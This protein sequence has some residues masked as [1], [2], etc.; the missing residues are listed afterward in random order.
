MEATEISDDYHGSDHRHENHPTSASERDEEGGE[1]EVFGVER[2][3]FYCE[4]CDSTDTSIQGLQFHFAGSRHKRK[5]EMAGLSIKLTP[6]IERPKNLD[7]WKTMVKCLLCKDMMLGCDCLIHAQSL[8]HQHKLSKMSG[9]RNQDFYTDIGNCFKPIATSSNFECLMGGGGD[10]GKFFCEPCKLELSSKQH[11]EIHVSGK[12]H[13]KR[14]RWLFISDAEGSEREYRQVWCSLCR[15]FVT[16]VKDFDGHIKGRTH[17]KALKRAGVEWQLL[18]STYGEN[19][20]GAQVPP[21]SHRRL[22]DRKDHTTSSSSTGTRRLSDDRKDRHSTRDRS[23][24]SARERS[25]SRLPRQ[26]SN[27]AP[28]SSSPSSRARDD[29]SPSPVGSRFPIHLPMPMWKEA[30]SSI[31]HY[32]PGLPRAHVLREGMRHVTGRVIHQKPLLAIGEWAGNVDVADPRLKE[33]EERVRTVT[34]ERVVKETRARDREEE[35]GRGYGGG[36]SGRGGFRGQGGRGRPS[37]RSMSRGG[38][39]YGER[40][41]LRRKL[42][43]RDRRHSNS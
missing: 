32:H 22:S 10:S 24:A 13:T 23:T 38:G 29:S 42:S 30:Y 33:M 6:L 5:L 14:M 8:A 11:L 17:M 20:V 16:T 35:R 3:H 12:K 1:E 2:T 40:N 7:I 9:Q 39:G 41:D 31:P 37:S 18:I 28:N 25:R 21:P 15:I 27:R 43:Y 34:R 36:Y 26:H 19:V 4:V